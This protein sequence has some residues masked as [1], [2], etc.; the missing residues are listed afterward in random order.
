VCI[1]LALIKHSGKIFNIVDMHLHLKLND[2]TVS[3]NAILSS[4]QL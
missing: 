4:L 1:L 2:H 3:E